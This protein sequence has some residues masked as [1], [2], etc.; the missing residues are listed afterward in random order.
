MSQIIINTNTE[1]Q[2]SKIIQFASS[3]GATY[4][5][6]N[7]SEINTQKSKEILIKELKGDRKPTATILGDIINTF[8]ENDWEALKS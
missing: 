8:D 1:E 6:N 2:A 3:I 4:S 7:S 5:L